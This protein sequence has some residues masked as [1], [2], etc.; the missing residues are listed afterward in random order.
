MWYLYIMPLI[1]IIGC[2]SNS[3]S[4]FF[5]LLLMLFLLLVV[6]LWQCFSPTYYFIIYIFCAIFFRLFCC[7][8]SRSCSVICSFSRVT[9]LL[10]SKILFF[11]VMTLQSLLCCSWFLFSTT[12]GKVF[13][14]CAHSVYFVCVH[15]IA[16]LHQLIQLIDTGTATFIQKLMKNDFVFAPRAIDIRSYPGDM[17]SLEE[18]NSF[19][20]IIVFFFENRDSKWYHWTR[21]KCEFQRH[22]HL[23]KD[24]RNSFVIPNTYQLVAVCL[25]NHKT[26]RMSER[27]FS[28]KW[29]PVLP[30]FQTIPNGAVYSSTNAIAIAITRLKCCVFV[31]HFRISVNNVSMDLDCRCSPKIIWCIRW[32]W[33][34]VQHWSC[35]RF[36]WKG[37]EA[38]VRAYHAIIQQEMPVIVRRR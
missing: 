7:T 12:W 9:R 16:V 11:V 17:H 4:I 14:L 27:K 15:L 25:A 10:H 37:L 31:F 3:L 8:P 30:H 20:I 29:N 32:T 38:R 1:I 26:K 24:V 23:L 36:Y 34:S 28:L 21:F 18:C 19:E 13:N 33:N 5:W 35:D 22:L 6:F 2:S